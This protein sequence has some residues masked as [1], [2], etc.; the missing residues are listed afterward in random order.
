MPSKNWFGNEWQQ[1]RGAEGGVEIKK[2]VEERVSEFLHSSKLL[3]S[4]LYVVEYRGKKK[5]NI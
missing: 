4:T 3:T 5:K 1:K 2:D